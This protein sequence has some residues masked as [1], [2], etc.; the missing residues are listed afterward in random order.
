MSWKHWEHINA[1]LMQIAYKRDKMDDV[2]SLTGPT[3]VS[4]WDSDYGYSER[5]IWISGQEISK[6]GHAYVNV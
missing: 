6:H 3:Y 5:P 4:N 2:I 1:V